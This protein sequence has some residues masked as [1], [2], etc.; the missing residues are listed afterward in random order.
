M[1]VDHS[2]CC[3]IIQ[4]G[5]EGWKHGNYLKEIVIQERG[6]SGFDQGGCSAG[7]KGSHSGYILRVKPVGIAVE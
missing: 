5:A 6:D 1:P 3:E 4:H 7:E 2:G